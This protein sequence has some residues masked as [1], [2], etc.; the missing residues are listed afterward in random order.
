MSKIF[1]SHNSAIVKKGE[2]SSPWAS[3][4]YAST[5]WEASKQARAEVQKAKAQ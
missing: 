1:H 2:N 5:S 4:R 3:L